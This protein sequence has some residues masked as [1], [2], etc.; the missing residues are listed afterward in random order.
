VGEAARRWIADSAVSSGGLVVAACQS[1]GLP[2][3]EARGQFW[4]RP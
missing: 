2:I 3:W 1:G 4:Y